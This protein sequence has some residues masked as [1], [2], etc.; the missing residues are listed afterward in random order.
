MSLANQSTLKMLCDQIFWERLF[1]EERISVKAWTVSVVKSLATWWQQHLTTCSSK[2]MCSIA[3][4]EGVWESLQMYDTVHFCWPFDHC[5]RGW[6]KKK[7]I[8]RLNDTSKFH[9][10]QSNKKRMISGWTVGLASFS[11]RRDKLMKLGQ[12]ADFNVVLKFS[13]LWSF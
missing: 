13:Q 12:M 2:M 1:S 3:A 11:D 5:D 8:G 4:S 9:Q 7:T 10:E 6:R